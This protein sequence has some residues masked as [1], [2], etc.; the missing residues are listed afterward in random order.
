M[1]NAK[2]YDILY[3]M[4]K[5]G[6]FTSRIL[7]A[8]SGDIMRIILTKATVSEPEK[9]SNIEIR[10]LYQSAF[11]LINKYCFAGELPEID[12]QPAQDQTGECAAYFDFDTER[13]EKPY[14][15]LQLDP[16]YSDPGNGITEN[17]I[18]DL[19]HE[20][21]H[22]HCYLKQIEDHRPRQFHTLE[23][24][25]AV[26]THGGICEYSDDENGYNDAHLNA[27]TLHRIYNEI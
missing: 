26:E 1:T 14:I 25:K 7:F 22:Y 13:K 24:K 11:R 15:V 21:I 18:D 8:K 19:F 4:G 17:D 27:D 6:L 2:R 5:T 16:Y 3:V 10:E 9:L 20:L 23:F 12:I